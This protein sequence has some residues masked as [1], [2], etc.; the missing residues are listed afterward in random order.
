MC[1]AVRDRCF[2]RL[3]VFAYS[4]EEGTRAYGLKGQLLAKVKQERLE[5][6]MA[7][8]QDISRSLLKKKTGKTL[9]V[10]VDE[11]RKGTKVYVGRTAQD[12]PEVDGRVFLSARASLVPGQFVRCRVTKT[13]DHDLSGEVIS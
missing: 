2:D 4:R 3:G 1:D 13:F 12:A 11:R 5:T 10:M 7:L 9:D 8:Q 6:L